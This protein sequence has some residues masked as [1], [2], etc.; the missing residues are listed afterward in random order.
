MLSSLEM[1]TYYQTIQIYIV[2]FQLREQSIN[3]LFNII[4]YCQTAFLKKYYGNV[5]LVANFIY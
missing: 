2:P 5:L 1:K 4:I 3:V